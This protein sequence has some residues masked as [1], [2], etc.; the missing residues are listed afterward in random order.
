VRLVTYD[1]ASPVESRV[2]EIATE[3]CELVRRPCYEPADVDRRALD[4][5][6]APALAARLAD[7]LERVAR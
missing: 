1:D 6:S 3:L 5:V 4:A 7:V 2:A